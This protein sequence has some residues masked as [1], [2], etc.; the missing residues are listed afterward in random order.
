MV[1]LI[2]RRAC[3]A[4]IDDAPRRV[5][6]GN[7][8]HRSMIRAVAPRMYW[9]LF[10]NGELRRSTGQRTQYPLAQVGPLRRCLRLRPFG[11]FRH[12]QCRGGAN[13]R[14]QRRFINL[15]ALMKI[16]GT[17]GIAFEAGVEKA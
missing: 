9:T 12:I 15:F 4:C 2:G 6:F 17:P 1:M 10:L 7:A 11:S 16:D 5:T 13:E 3:A 14:F 8:L